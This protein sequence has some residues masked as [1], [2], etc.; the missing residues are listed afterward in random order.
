MSD[1]GKVFLV[2]APLSNTRVGG[3][4]HA[5]EKALPAGVQRSLLRCCSSSRQRS[6]P[7]LNTATH[8]L[9][10]AYGRTGNEESSPASEPSGSPHECHYVLDGGGPG[11]RRA[12][13]ADARVENIIAVVAPPRR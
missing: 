2:S 8:K 10:V 5:S 11:Y 9:Y 4:P 13:A 3:T 1:A 7:R 6:R 12:V